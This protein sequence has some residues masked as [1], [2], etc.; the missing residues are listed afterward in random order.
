MSR[1]TI[2]VRPLDH[3]QGD[4]RAVSMVANGSVLTRLLRQNDVHEDQAIRVPV[5]PLAFWMADHW[6]RLRWEC[7]PLSGF[8]NDW[9]QAH[10]MAAIGAGYAWPRVT[11]W[12]EGERTVIVSRADPV[13]VAGP[14]RLLQNAIGFVPATDFEGAVDG[15]LG[16]SAAIATGADGAALAALVQALHDERATPDIATWRRLEAINGFDPDQAPDSLIEGQ[17]RLAARFTLR[18]IEEIAASSPGDASE[19]TLDDLIDITSRESS[20]PVMFDRA[21]AAGQTA[22]NA[23]CNEPWELA[24]ATA[25]AVRRAC[26][27]GKRPLRNAA[28]SELIGIDPRALQTSHSSQTRPYGLRIGTGKGRDRVLLQARW[29]HDRRFEVM[30]SLG[31]AIWTQNSPLGPMSR[32]GTA[33]QKFQRAFAASMLCPAD[34]LLEHLQ[35]DAP[36]EG[37][38]SEGARHFHVAEQAVRTV[39]VNKG[40][41][42]RGRLLAADGA[43]DEG[44]LHEILNAA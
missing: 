42:E 37:D 35:T 26:G 29:A 13:G 12:G 20:Y 15:F 22:A 8:P 44:R 18:D 43:M 4:V 9:R 7:R 38:I 23:R 3:A 19:A 14:V 30:R 40:L 5:T 28:L 39:L 17:L 16:A 31:D 21:I 10:D 25:C 34:A 11:I 36:T 41:L 6:W 33:R 1:F 2:D 32:S 24:E 27:A